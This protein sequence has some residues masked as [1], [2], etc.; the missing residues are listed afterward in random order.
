M[1]IATAPN[2]VLFIV[3]SLEVFLF[4]FLCYFGGRRGLYTAIA[5]ILIAVSLF[6]AELISV[7]GKVTNISN[8]FY[9]AVFFVGQLIVEHYGKTEAKKT[10]WLGLA[11]TVLLLAIGRMVG[12]FTPI[13]ESAAISHAVNNIFFTFAPRVALASLI[14]YPISQRV[15]IELYSYIGRVNQKQLWL[16]SLIANFGGQL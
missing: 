9:A 13:P 8:I 10:I 3:T 16:R 7:F 1:P 12:R 11:Y 14:A 5:I 2:E 15:N 6:G 4:V